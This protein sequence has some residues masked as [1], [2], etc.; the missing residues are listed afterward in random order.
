MWS[1]KQTF[2]SISP[3][4]WKFYIVIAIS[5]WLS[6]IIFFNFYYFHITIIQICWSSICNNNNVISE[7]LTVYKMFNVVTRH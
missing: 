1:E 4:T 6:S 3:A 2:W 7:I 5:K